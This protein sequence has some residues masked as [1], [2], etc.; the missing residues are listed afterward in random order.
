MN[1]SIT[2]V[3]QSAQNTERAEKT[4][5]PLEPEKKRGDREVIP[6]VQPRSS[7]QTHQ[8]KGKLKNGMKTIKN[9]VKQTFSDMYSK[10]KS[11]A[12]IKGEPVPG[13]S[14][15]RSTIKENQTSSTSS[16]KERDDF[17][18]ATSVIFQQEPSL[19]N[20]LSGP[21]SSGSDKSTSQSCSKL[22]LDNEEFG[23]EADHKTARNKVQASLLFSCE[24]LRNPDEISVDMKGGQ[25]LHMG[26][27]KYI[28]KYTS[29]RELDIKHE[30][31]PSDPEH[32]LGPNDMKP[33]VPVSNDNHVRAQDS[34][35]NQLCRH[36]SENKYKHGGPQLENVSATIPKSCE[37]LEINPNENLQEH[38]QKFL[39]EISPLQVLPASGKEKVQL[40]NENPSKEK[41][42][43]RPNCP[44]RVLIDN[45][46]LEID[47]L[48]NQIRV[49]EKKYAED[50]EFMKAKNDDLQQNLNRS[51][52][53]LRRTTFQYSG[54][55]KEL[56]AENAR[57]HS[58]LEDE[59]LNQQR[60]ETDIDSLQSRVA[61]AVQDHERSQKS[62]C[63]LELSLQTA[64]DVCLHIQ[65][66]FKTDLSKLQE[67]NDT[68]CQKLS[69]M[70]TK[71][72]SLESEFTKKKDALQEEIAQLQRDLN[73]SQSQLKETEHRYQNA[74][75]KVCESK[76][77]E[78]LLYERLTRLQGENDSLQQKV[79]EAENKVDT[80]EKKVTKLQDQFH[81]LVKTYHNE[82]E[83][84]QELE[85]RIK[86]LSNMCDLLQGRL[87]QCE[88][89]KAERKIDP[90]T[91]K[92]DTVYSKW[93]SLEIQNQ[94]LQQEL[95][96]MKDTQRKCEKL[97]KKKGKLEQKVVQLQRELDQNQSK[98]GQVDQF[99]WRVEEQTEEVVYELQ[100][101]KM[102]LQRQAQSQGHREYLWEEQTASLRREME[103][104][105]KGLEHEFSSQIYSQRT[106]AEKYKQLYLQELEV[107]KEFSKQLD[108]NTERLSEVSANLALEKQQNQTL[109]NSLV[110]QQAREASFLGTA[111]TSSIF[112]RNLHGSS[113]RK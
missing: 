84:R 105:M 61:A 112:H 106:E 92:W 12:H 56:T 68:L 74:P 16:R 53:S 37:T 71:F 28:C 41:P 8:G 55:L 67:T 63:E 80:E 46:Q 29:K 81:L 30:H 66:K 85:E 21:S 75:E 45:L 69:E 49:K 54:Q 73:Q 27:E 34:F 60:L 17:E 109:F 13:N 100:Q 111:P 32:H 35:Q 33:V 4:Q 110:M 39:H 19:E 99:T 26:R 22:S 101:V 40:Q 93:Q 6:H 94:A 79:H 9:V 98:L 77:A 1:L 108:K 96:A 50:M 70:E 24:N 102:S 5:V 104:R 86:E 7:L 47:A 113:S 95:S 97:E 78:K 83:K 82:S 62:K 89:E 44:F 103:Q 2:S 43:S 31:K 64:R 90:L 51:E 88:K 11:M 58:K 42:D 57:L 91:G 65:K 18:V 87:C 59:K 38:M 107:K 3:K 20:V 48:K 52:E 36:R 10:Y 72:S 76:N 14:K 23:F 25:E 15:E